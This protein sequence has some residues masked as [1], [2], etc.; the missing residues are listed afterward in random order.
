MSENNIIVAGIPRSGT[1][2]LF[3][4]IAGFPPGISKPENYA[5]PVHK[6]HACAPETFSKNSVALFV[7]GDPVC[8]VLSTRKNRWR[9]KHFLNC[10]VDGDP[11]DFDN[12]TSDCLGYEQMFDTWM[13]PHSYPVLC[14]RYEAMP[15]LFTQIEAFIGRSILFPEWKSRTTRLEEY[16]KDVI[17]AIRR[18][19]ATLIDKVA[20]APDLSLWGVRP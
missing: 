7:F 16:P 13:R 17:T 11:N 18:T 12:Y 9:K 19:Y 20:A 2:Y 15:N 5:G 4:A 3:R 8:S 6:T 10:G 1:T 14:V